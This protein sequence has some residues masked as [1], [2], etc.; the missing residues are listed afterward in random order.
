MFER[1]TLLLT[2][3]YGAKEAS[4]AWGRSVCFMIMSCKFFIASLPPSTQRYS[5]H[6]YRPKLQS[7][8]RD[9]QLH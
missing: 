5:T 7:K 6:R 1:F 9:D 2:G 3:A 4:E 8:A